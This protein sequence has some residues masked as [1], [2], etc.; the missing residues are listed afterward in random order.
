MMEMVRERSH[1]IMERI[2]ELERTKS[3][4]LSKRKGIDGFVRG[5]RKRPLVVTEFDEKL[6]LAVIDRVVVDGNGGMVFHF[7]NGMEVPEK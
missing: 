5:I 6:W 1:Q 2:N 4:R 7:K 3:E